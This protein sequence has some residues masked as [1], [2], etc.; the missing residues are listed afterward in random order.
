M[1][2]RSSA[3]AIRTIL[4]VLFCFGLGLSATLGLADVIPASSIGAEPRE[5]T[6]P[7]A[8]QDEDW[9]P[10]TLGQASHG[11]LLFV[12][13]QPGL[14][15]PAPRLDTEVS[16]RITGWV[17]RARV[18]QRFTNPHDQWLEGIYAFPLPS[19]AAVDALELRIGERVI[20]GEIQERAA[21]RE[22]YEEAKTSGKK[23]SLVEQERPNL[24]TTSVANIGPG[25]TVD[26]VI[27]YQQ[28]LA[29]R[30]G[31]FE[32]RFPM[33]VNPRYIPGHPRAP[34]A[35]PP[36]HEA[37]TIET[38]AGDAD[39]RTPPPYSSYG[40]ATA[41]DQVPDAGRITPP[42]VL[43]TG[44]EILNPVTLSVDIDLGLPIDRLTSPSHPLEI[45]RRAVGSAWLTP[46]GGPVPANRDFVLR[47][48]PTRGAEPT[49]A[50]LAEEYGGETYYLLMVV[51]PA[52]TPDAGRVPRE[53]IFVLDTS[54]SMAGT[55]IRQAKTALLDALG[56][57]PSGDTFNVIDFDSDARRL[58][59]HPVPADPHHLGVATRWIQRLRA[60]GGTE[61]QAAFDLA[62]ADPSEG[63]ET[64]AGTAGDAPANTLRQVVFITDGSV[65]NEAEL[66]RHLTGSLGRSRLF[67]IAI[68]SAPN[69]YFLRRAAEIGGGTA[70][71]IASTRDVTERMD[72][73]F[74]KI[75]HPVLS[76]LEVL[77]DDTSVLSRPERP[78]DLY[79][80]EPL[81]LT[82]RAGNTEPSLRLRGWLGDT[83]WQKDLETHGAATG[84]GLHKLWARREI[85]ALDDS[86]T[87]LP[88]GDSDQRDQWTAQLVDVALD[89]HLVSRFT[90]LV[91][92]DTTP[93]R[94]HDAAMQSRPLPIQTPAGWTPPGT[95][96]PSGGTASRLQ[97][98]AGLV[99]LLLTAMAAR[100]GGSS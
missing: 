25:E 42:H 48:W 87:L 91:A 57:L 66:L 29:W 78:G 6:E 30:D 70:T 77:W 44:G 46:A 94:P 39:D 52:P 11:G 69:G 86:L 84:D 50:V 64:N 1:S 43:I 59:D 71:F 12:T 28:D 26:V 89:H 81:V 8:A 18:R 38:A 73:L 80:G 2:Y 62:L 88:P 17:T 45:E 95:V 7:P 24:F 3:A 51:P 9:R 61:M 23:A 31:R 22:V 79:L 33:V 60:G 97:I 63:L 54:G 16:I 65:G 5:P 93:T 67:P 4:V 21:A 100:R 76:D 90:S 20:V 99:L 72:E 27:E 98:A 47:L 75:E 74:T 96:L 37:D 14:Y 85:A 92:V 53:T 49:A 13:D 58:F 35:S 41:T 15:A 55:S 10:V 32:L 82:A 19:G 68:G 40:W 34:P 83:P 56:R 36:R